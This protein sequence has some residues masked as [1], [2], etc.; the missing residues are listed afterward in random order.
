[1]HDVQPVVAVQQA[2]VAPDLLQVVQEVPQLTLLPH[3]N[4]SDITNVSA[5]MD[6]KTLSMYLQNLPILPQLEFIWEI[7][8]T[9]LQTMISQLLAL[10]C[11]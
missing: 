5:L 6:K 8:A 9:T 3:V 7:V 11:Q 2:E 10:L 1:M 4:I